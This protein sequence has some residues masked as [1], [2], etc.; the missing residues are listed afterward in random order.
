VIMIY[1]IC[2]NI[3]PAIIVPMFCGKATFSPLIV[4]KLYQMLIR[5]VG[6]EVVVQWSPFPSPLPASDWV[7]ARCSFWLAGSFGGHFFL[8]TSLHHVSKVEVLGSLGCWIMFLHSNKHTGDSTTCTVY[9]IASQYY[10]Y[11]TERTD[12][13][14]VPSSACPCVLSDVCTGVMQAWAEKG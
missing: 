13:Q 10:L 1:C 2:E 12:K 3:L 9:T 7:G 8:M 11:Q 4:F 5:S 14:L 6:H